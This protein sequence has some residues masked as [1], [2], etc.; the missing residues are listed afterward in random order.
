M[1]KESKEQT[2][3]RARRIIES[4]SEEFPNPETALIHRNP[5]ELLV[6]TVLSAQCTDERVNKVTPQ[7]FQEAPDAKTLGHLPLPRIKHLIKSI[8]F[9]PTKAKNLK[10]LGTLLFEK[11]QGEVPKSLDELV[12]LPGVGRK[13]A[14]VVLANAFGI[15][16]VVVDTHVGR[17]ARRLNLSRSEKPDVV[18]SDL[19]KLFERQ[20]WR[21]LSHYFILHGRKTC[22]ARSPKCEFCLVLKD[23]PTGAKLMS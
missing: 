13:T 20:H 8:N 9:F 14:N 1:P 5:F 16:R 19:E 4:L 6:A 21:D 15:P 2:K 11:F 22:Q 18:E 3:A 10:A 17:L 23:C 12:T 7:L